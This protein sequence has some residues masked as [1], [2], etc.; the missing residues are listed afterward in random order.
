MKK[1][2]YP[3]VSILS[4]DFVIPTWK[5]RE[6]EKNKLE[7]LEEKNSFIL[8]KAKRCT[9]WCLKAPGEKMENLI[10]SKPAKQIN[11]HFCITHECTKYVVLCFLTAG[12]W[13]AH[14]H[15]ILFNHIHF[16]TANQNSSS[17][18]CSQK[19]ILGD[20]VQYHKRSSWSY[21]IVFTLR[22]WTLK[23]Y[24]YLLKGLRATNHT[25]N[26]TGFTSEISY[27]LVNHGI[28]IL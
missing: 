4:S 9:Y 18:P 8:R 12:H 15:E 21:G 27:L 17:I 2:S 14:L 1:Y 20:V 22:C 6:R 10:N 3:L 24:S 28:K 11:Q 25:Q 5:K 16:I 26:S 13:L 23:I 19:I 7:D